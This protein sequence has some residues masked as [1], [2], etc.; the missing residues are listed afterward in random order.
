MNTV[1]K[2]VRR[3][4]RFDWDLA[5]TSAAVNRPT[6]IAVIGL[7]YISFENERVES[8]SRLTSSAREFTGDLEAQLAVPISFCGTSPSGIIQR[9]SA[10][11]TRQL[12]G[13]ASAL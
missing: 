10:E 5:R 2:K 4:G 8:Y 9:E 12:L 3:V 1:S 6:K 13:G 11:S 7:D